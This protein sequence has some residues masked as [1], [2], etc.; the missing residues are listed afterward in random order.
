M[1]VAIEIRH[2]SQSPTRRKPGAVKEEKMM[3]FQGVERSV[4]IF[5]LTEKDAQQTGCT[6]RR[7]RAAVD[8]R[9]SLTRRR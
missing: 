4:I 7:D 6:E 8:N 9:T 3:R 1:Y 2:T 5:E